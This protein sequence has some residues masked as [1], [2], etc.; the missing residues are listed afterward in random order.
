[1]AVSLPDELETRTISQ[2]FPGESRFVVPWAMYCETDR[3]LW[4]NGNHSV[5]VAPHGTRRMLIK[6]VDDGFEVNVCDLGHQWSPT[7]PGYSGD[8]KPVPVV[9]LIT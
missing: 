4:L 2:M 9:N 8:F 3:T 1:M 5:G 6:R 7:G